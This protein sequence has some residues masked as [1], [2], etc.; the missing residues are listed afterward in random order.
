[1]NRLIILGNGFDLAHG[2]KT[3]YEDYIKNYWSKV[4]SSNH[5]DWFLSFENTG[6]NFPKLE[7][8]KDLLDFMTQGSGNTLAPVGNS[9][10]Y[11]F[12]NRK[13]I[14]ISNRFFNKINLIF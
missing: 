10:H 8:L 3:K 6:T 7:N 11:C 5:S 1:M 13:Y 9:P 12:E 4:T 14:N 2:L